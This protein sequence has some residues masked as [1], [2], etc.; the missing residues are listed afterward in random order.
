MTDKE[1]LNIRISLIFGAIWGIAFI[2]AIQVFVKLVFNY[3][4]I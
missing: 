1:K 3:S 4:L 2:I